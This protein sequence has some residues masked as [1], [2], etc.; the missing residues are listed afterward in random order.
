MVACVVCVSATYVNH[1]NLAETTQ[2]GAFFDPGPIPLI[3]QKRSF[4]GLE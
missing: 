4:D 3:R 1:M 2:K